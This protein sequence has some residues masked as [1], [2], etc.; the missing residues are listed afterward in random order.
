MQHP[1]DAIRNE[2]QTDRVDI[3]RRNGFDFKTEQRVND[4]D[5]GDDEVGAKRDIFMT[6]CVG[7]Q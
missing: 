3:E 7:L 6:R 1:T 4:E 2:K 5:G